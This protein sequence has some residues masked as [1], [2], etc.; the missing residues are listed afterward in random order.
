ML[1]T[2]E[3]LINPATSG[4]V[5]IDATNGG[6][7]YFD[8]GDTAGVKQAIFRDSGGAPVL[9]INSDGDAVL[10]GNLQVKGDSVIFETGTKLVEDNLIGLNY[11]ASGGAPTLVSAGIYIQRE[12]LAVEGEPT[13]GTAS[14]TH[15]QFIWHESNDAWSIQVNATD[16]VSIPYSN[17]TPSTAFAAS[18]PNLAT[19]GA[20]VGTS[21]AAQIGVYD[22]SSFVF[23]A[24]PGEVQ[25]ALRQ[26]DAAIDGLGVTGFATPNLTLGTSN[27]AGSATTVI[28]SDAT[29]LVFDGT[30]PANVSTSGATGSATVTARR[31]HVHGHGQII[32]GAS[33]ANSYH[34]ARDVNTTNFA[35]PSNYTPV[36]GSDGNANFVSVEDH[37]RAI[38]TAIGTATANAYGTINGNTGTAVAASASDTI[39]I[40]GTDGISAVA[41]NGSPDTLQFSP[42]FA[43]PGFTLGIAAAAG[44]ASSFV[45]SDATIAIFDSTNPTTIQPDDAAAVGTAAF[46][47][48]RDHQHAIATDTPVGI[49]GVLAEGTSTSFARADHVHT[50]DFSDGANVKGGSADIGS[51]S[52]SVAVTFSTAFSTACTRVVCT[53]ENT[54]DG[55]PL[56]IVVTITAR[57]TTGFTATLSGATDSANYDLHWVAYGS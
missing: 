39:T 41:T 7:I 45:R 19:R 5:T 29:I 15:R 40:T 32:G 2:A 20:A 8:L 1:L 54:T 6:N 47:A 14:A 50:V 12:D 48:R 28:R 25:E 46:T 26:L 23:I 37:L 52:T 30:T 3:G 13:A 4:N 9:T 55:S 17:G 24:T 34:D 38:D 35:S 56:A 53:I 18:N 33:L 21:G 49:G 22:D 10:E 51:G 57:T 16:I 36:I 27:A 31:D 11:V 44:S 42:T 43:A